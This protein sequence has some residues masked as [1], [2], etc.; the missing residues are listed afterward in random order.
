MQFT[1]NGAAISEREK[2]AYIDYVQA[3]APERRI[4]YIKVQVDG[5]FADLE[6]RFVEVPFEPDPA[7]YRISCRYHGPGGTTRNGQRSMTVSNTAAVV[8]NKTNA[9]ERHEGC[10]SRLFSGSASIH[11]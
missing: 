2:Q 8:R 1:V 4:D 10:G 9:R 7:D 6:Y 3:K 11:P 5:D